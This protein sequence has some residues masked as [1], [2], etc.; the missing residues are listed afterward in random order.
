[1]RFFFRKYLSLSLNLQI[2]TS[3]YN[4][5][6][7]NTYN[8]YS[9]I[10]TFSCINKLFFVSANKLR[11]E[12]RGYFPEKPLEF[13]FRSRSWLDL[14]PINPVGYYLRS[15]SSS[16]E[17]NSSTF[18]SLEIGFEELLMFKVDSWYIVIS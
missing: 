12:L 17:D 10:C 11:T 13:V 5:F 8:S 15:V 16:V 14:R 1:L 18:R 9:Y 7:F 6:N 2:Y 4:I 3:N